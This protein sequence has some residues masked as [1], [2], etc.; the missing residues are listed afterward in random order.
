M[1]ASPEPETAADG[2]VYGFVGTGAITAALVEGLHAGDGAD[3]G[4]DPPTVYLSPRNRGVAQS[5]SHRFPDVHVCA[6]NQDVLDRVTSVVVAVRPQVAEEVLA[7]LAFAPR[8]VAISVV[9]GLRLDRLRAWV[10]P[11]TSIA[12]AIPL[13]AAARRRSLT[14]LHPDHPAA[15]GLFDRVGESLVTEDEAAFEAIAAVTATFAAHLDYL[16]TI[17]GWLADH[18]VDD[19]AATAYLAHV[20]GQLGEALPGA[21]SFAA[22]TGEYMTPGGINEQFLADLRAA[23]TPDAVRRAL[24]RVLARL[25]G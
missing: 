19:R 11:A 25:Q 1:A 5:L 22:L 13:P 10:A 24:D 15:R 20:F 7:E 14:A 18:S 6:S 2:A 12:R 9:A 16:A 17:A 21:P 3:P 23:G 8:H 4:T